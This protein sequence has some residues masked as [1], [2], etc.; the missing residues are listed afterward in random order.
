MHARGIKMFR[1]PL[2]KTGKSKCA[3]KTL[4]INK[5]SLKKPLTASSMLSGKKLIYGLLIM[6]FLWFQRQ[7][8]VTVL[9]RRL[10]EQSTPTDLISVF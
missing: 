8:V 6:L 9:S 5:V 7:L 1:S 4:C 3:A 10:A 2:F